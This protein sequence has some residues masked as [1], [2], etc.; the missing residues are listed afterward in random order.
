LIALALLEHVLL[1]IGT[2]GALW[3]MF[4]VRGRV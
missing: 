4:V 3:T 2:G 1:G